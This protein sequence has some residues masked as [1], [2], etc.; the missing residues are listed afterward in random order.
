MPK[1]ILASASPRRRKLMSEEGYHFEVLASDAEEIS[2]KYMIPSELTVQNAEIKATLVAKSNK[3]SVVIG[4]DTVVSLDNEIFGKPHDLEE[5]VKMLARLAGRTHIVTT[6]VSIIQNTKKENFHVN[7][8]VTFKPLSEEE[9]S[10]YV[11]LI[12]PLDKAGSYAAQDHGEL[13]IEKHEGSFSNVVGL[14]MDELKK[15][16]AD[17]FQSYP[18]N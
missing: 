11:K 6:G 8:E 7:T 3:E 15:A 10:Q 9:I 13:I 4:A 12:N 5:A 1:I 17:S 18:V 16:L 14:P 2:E